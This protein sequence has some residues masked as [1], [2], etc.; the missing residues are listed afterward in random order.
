MAESVLFLTNHFSPRVGLRRA[1]ASPLN[2]C[3]S[4]LQ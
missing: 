3:A 4:S 1:W 2:C